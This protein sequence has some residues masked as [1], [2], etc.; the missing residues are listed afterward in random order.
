MH[1]LA[2]QGRLLNSQRFERRALQAVDHGK[3]IRHR[4]SRARPAFDQH[5]FAE[6]YAG[7]E[8]H[9]ALEISAA[10][11]RQLDADAAACED[12]E[13]IAG[14]ARAE[15]KLAGFKLAARQTRWRNRTR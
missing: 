14:I 12:V 9:Q 11:D 5:L 15:Q 1:Q 8:R 7:A 4:I 6:H 2:R 10:L 3:F 13:R